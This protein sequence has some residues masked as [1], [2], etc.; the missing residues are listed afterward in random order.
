MLD[1]GRELRWWKAGGNGKWR[2]CWGD[3]PGALQLEF[4]QLAE[5][6]GKLAYGKLLG[7][8]IKL[9]DGGVEAIPRNRTK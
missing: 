7:L 8:S 2:D 6:L 4:G 1:F 9:S 5:L 3:L